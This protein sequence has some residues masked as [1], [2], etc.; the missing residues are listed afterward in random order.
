MATPKPKTFPTLY[1]L[2]NT[3]KLQQWRIS[4]EMLDFGHARIFT[5][6]GQVGGKATHATDLVTEGKNEGKKNATTPYQQAVNEAE[7]RWKH[8]KDREGYTE[9]PKAA[10]TNKPLAPMLA[11]SIED[12]DPS[13]LIWSSAFI[14][15]KLDGFRCLAKW[16]A[17]LK[18][19]VL[20]S[21]QKKEIDTLPHLVER[22]TPIL[23]KHKDVILDGELYAHGE[24]F[25][26]IQSWIKRNQS[27][28]SKI[29]YNLYD[30]VAH[31][32]FERRYE[33][34]RDIVRHESN[35][36]TIVRTEK[37][38]NMEQVEN[39]QRVVVEEGYEGAMLR[40]SELSYEIGKRS[41]SLLKV[42]TFMDAEF[43]IVGVVPGN[44]GTHA[45]MAM[46]VCT[47]SAGAKFEV[48]AHGSHPQKR[49]ILKEWQADPAAFLKKNP[50]ITVKYFGMTD[51]EEP[52]PRFPIAKAFVKE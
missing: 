42:K 37:V 31:T 36:M 35:L 12:V 30:L 11:Q 34:L 21:R 26:S 40:Q 38:D 22:L 17:K 49:A 19:V 23:S 43:D 4:V 16:D 32:S 5:L 8:K 18:K 7:S 14:Q 51:S 13:K 41:K 45:E 3:G 48:V 15:P 6:Y 28:S 9:D 10:E 2:A 29:A 46:I 25:Q 27:D 44:K 39:F 20:I 33:Q 50:K 24:S 52:V 1:K 47:T